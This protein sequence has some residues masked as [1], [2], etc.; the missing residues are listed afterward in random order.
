MLVKACIRERAGSISRRSIYFAIILVL[1]LVLFLPFPLWSQTDTLNT[2][3]GIDLRDM[4][5]KLSIRYYIAEKGEPPARYIVLG[6]LS[7]YPNF[8]GGTFDFRKKV[9][10]FDLLSEY[11]YTF[12]VPAGYRFSRNEERRDAFYYYNPRDMALEGMEIELITLDEYV[13]RVREKSN[14][15]IW[16]EDIKYSLQRE[17][18]GKAGKGLLSIDIPIP[19]PKQLERI[20]G[21]GKATNLTVQGRESI[22]IGGKSNWC[23]NCPQTEGRPQQNKFPDLD[24]QQR[25]SV[26]LHGN[27]GEKINV[28]I[29]HSSQGTGIGSTNRVRMNY[30]GFDDEIIKLIEMGDTD[31]TLRGA[32]L[33]SYSGTAK[34]LFGI[35]TVAQVGPMELTVIASKEEGETATGTFTAT[36]G[37]TSSWKVADYGFIKRQFFFFETPGDNFKDAFDDPSNNFRRIYPVVGGADNDEMEVFISLK[38]HEYGQTGEAEYFMRAYPVPDNKEID[39]SENS[40]RGRFRKLDI[41]EDFEL[42]QEY[43]SEG[44]T[45]YIGMRLFQTL[46]DGRALVVRYKSEDVGTAAKYVVGDYREFSASETDTLT[47][48]LICPPYE[49][50]GAD[51]TVSPY[52]STWKMMMRNIYS[53]GSGRIDPDAPFRVRIERNVNEDNN[54]IHTES[55]ILYLRLFGLDRYDRTGAAARDDEVDNVPG[56]LNLADGYIMLPWFEP[57]DVPYEVMVDANKFYVAEPFIN[58]DDPGESDFDDATLE[59]NNAIY[60]KV[61]TPSLKNESHLYDVVVEAS[62]GQRTFQLA[63]FDIIE[64]SEAITIDGVKLSRGADYDIDYMS[65]TVTLKGE[66][67]AELQAR[68]DARVSIDYQHV[69]IIGGGKSSLLGVGANIDLSK[70]SRLNLTYLY[71]STGS[72]KYSPR[73]GE[74]PGRNMAADINGNFTFNPRWMTSIA[75]ILPRVDTDDQSS[76]NIS[77]EMAMSIPNPN[78]KGEAFIDDMEGVEDSDAISLVRRNWF[79]ASPPLDPVTLEPLG[80]SVDDVPD[81]NWFNP[82]RTDQLDKWVTTR[83]DLNP[84]LDTRENSNI[85]SLF[86][87]VHNPDVAR[88][89]QWAGV[90]TGFPGGLDLTTT[91]YLEIW[92]NDYQIDPARRGGVLH[93]DIGKIDE[94][95]FEPE[96]DAFND[97]DKPPYTW[98]ADEDSGFVGAVDEKL[99]RDPY[100]GILNEATW[101]ETR[102]VYRGINSRILNGIHDSEDLNKNGRLDESNAY[103]ALELRLGDTALVDVREQYP[104]TD[105]PE[106]YAEREINRSKAWRMYRLDLSHVS[107]FLVSDMGGE[108]RWDAIQQMRLWVSGFDSLVGSEGHRIE[109]AGLK[110]VGNKWEYNGIRDLN[111]EIPPD[112]LDKTHPNQK[113]T[114]GVINNKDH[115]Q[116]RPPYPVGTE[117]GLENREQSL[118]VSVEKFADSTSFRAVKRFFGQGQSYQQYRELHLFI[119]PDWSG[120]LAGCDFYFQIAYD[121][122]SYYELAIPITNEM[123]GRWISVS[124]NLGDLTNLKLVESDEEIVTA[125]I[126]DVVNPDRSYTAKVRGNPT[127]FEVRN[128]YLGL[129]NTSGRL[130]DNGWLWFNDIKL[131]GV[132][133]DIDHAERVS[134]SANLANVIQLSGQWQR[135]GPEFRSL[136]QS[137]GSGVTNNAM[138]FSAKSRIDHFIPTLGFELPFSARVNS[139]TALPK[140]VPRSDVEIADEAIRE[141]QKS[142]NNSHSYNISLSRRG[143]RN[144]LMKTVFDNLKMSYSYSKKKIYSPTTRD[145]TVTHSGNLN[146]RIS[147]RRGRE[148][149]LFKGIKWRYWLSNFSLVSSASRQV[150]HTHSLTGDEFIK[151][152]VGYG[153]GLDNSVST[154]YE[155]FQSIKIELD[156]KEHRDRSIDHYILGIPVGVQTSFNHSLR[157]NFSPRGNFF[158]LSQFRPRIDYTSRYNEDLRPN[159]RQE[160]D[161]FGTRNVNAQRDMSFVFDVDI[162]DYSLMLGEFLHILPRGSSSRRS[163]GATRSTTME[164]REDRE[165][166]LRES[167]PSEFKAPVP[168]SMTEPQLLPGYDPNQIQPQQQPPPTPPEREEKSEPR[169]ETKPSDLGVTKQQVDV[170]TEKDKEPDEQQQ[171]ESDTTAA[172]KTDPLKI[173]KKLFRLMGRIEPLKSNI[174]HTRRSSYQRLYE[175]AGFA[176]QFGL[177]SKSGVLGRSKEVENNPER[178]N[179][180]LV[181]DLRSGIELAP[182]IDLDVRFNYVIAKSNHGGTVTRTER[183]TWPS[184]NLSWGGMENS[185]FLKSF[186]KQSDLKVSFEKKTSSDI[187]RDVT[188]YLLSPNWNFVWKNDL[189]TNV[190]VSYKRNV[191]IDNMQE[192]WSKGWGVTFNMKYN[193]SGTKGFGIPLPFLGR[194]KIKFKSTLTADLGISYNS[195]S[196]YNQRKSDN[197][198]SVT[199]RASYRFSNKISGTVSM[200]YVRSVAGQTGWINHSLGLHVTAEFTF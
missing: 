107:D 171:A 41:E 59:R 117:E 105:Y 90:M 172:S 53:L 25:L 17:R 68:P 198:L 120:N 186:I 66:V 72:P 181:F 96:L 194:K 60:N 153:S 164:T 95:F 36:G 124:I 127:L 119:Y 108:P 184:L 58:P 12:R 52:P 185:R 151:R 112:S 113:I 149:G 111:D 188:S 87:K 143:S 137:Q 77:A 132:R 46:A 101:D 54:H 147:F 37:Q 110:I 142:V 191:T 140:Y 47:A 11:V 134:L 51:S 4:S 62:S 65:G 109:I 19:L 157:L 168:T 5:E 167:R 160:G 48:E 114:I 144:F 79:E 15:E 126:Q 122:V 121:S 178:E 169:G 92:V 31:L 131:G 84:S 89:D 70:H 141:S 91:Q 82:S 23:A 20:I 24:M 103:Y 163:S 80:T 187:R 176:Y 145:T 130:I 138:A 182:R 170:P 3:L 189:T 193:F 13:R 150:R 123:S 133:R 18:K 33:I 7:I 27:I 93:I 136:R 43:S 155:P 159:I 192:I 56:I 1:F 2:D 162:G 30:I 99:Y 115:P 39:E 154:L 61:L 156:M 21:S 135:T 179:D 50:F 197:V 64:G 104:E 38:P 74:E 94:D 26:D 173:F 190:G 6:G 116:Y 14:R 34:G 75:N 98:T 45:R 16:I 49:D 148:L 158:I 152:P 8:L 55:N 63:A 81:F 88:D 166:R 183:V 129:R 32:Q 165:R 9:V 200:S 174:N 86:I 76:L 78:V 67:L 29:S 42:I 40:F 85:T 102:Q 35:K 100:P 139:S 28:E 128:L 71:N 199:P 73:L 97:E 146:Y 57:F 10:E 125:T 177:S 175:R 118:I 106:Y 180:N 195:S 22:T 83:W 69:P 161:P 196:K 44:V